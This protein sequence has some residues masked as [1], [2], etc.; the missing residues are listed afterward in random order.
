MKRR[1]TLHVEFPPPVGIVIRK[2]TRQVEAG[3]LVGCIHLE[4]SP[5]GIVCWQHP[6]M[7]RC[8]EC[9]QTHCEAHTVDEEH[10]C[11]ICGG[12]MPTMA[13][14]LLALLQPIEVDALVP[15]GRGRFAAVGQV[16]FVG[17]GAC[18]ECMAEVQQ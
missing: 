3:R 10:A 17:W 14:S 5:I 9:A 13:S 7:V 11:D 12:H 18:V 8:H 15:I 2:A 6:T 16:V 1:L 4:R